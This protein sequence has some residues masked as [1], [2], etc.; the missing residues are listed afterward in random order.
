MEKIFI[1]YSHKDEGWKERLVTHLKVLELEGFF[2]IWE[3]RQIKTGDDWLPEIETALNEVGIVIM[4]ISADFLVSGFIRGTEVPKIMERRKNEGIWVIPV[5]VK[6][7]PWKSVNWLSVIQS[8]PRDG[9]DLMS[10]AESEAELHLAELAELIVKRVKLKGEPRQ[11][12][13]DTGKPGFFPPGKLSLSKLPTPAGEFIGREMELKWL[14]DAW[15]DPGTHIVI[16]EAWGGVGKTAL[17]NKWL[18]HMGI[19]NYRGAEKVYG[20]SF[21]S[22]GAAEGKQASADEFIQ[23]TL[24][25]FGDPNP[26]EGAAYEKG[27]RLASLVRQQKTLLILD[28]LEPLQHPSKDMM[29][30]LKDQGLQALLKEL[31]Y[32]QPGLCIVTTRLDVKELAH[33]H[34]STVKHIPLENLSPEVGEALLRKLEVKGTSKEMQSASM[35][36]SGHALALTLLGNYLAAVHDGEIRKKDLIPYLTE[37]EEQGGHARRVM[38][39]Y[40]KWFDNG[41]EKDILYIIR[42]FDRP[43]PGSAIA[44]LREA[45]VIEG[46]TS[47][48]QNLSHSQWQFAVKRLRRLGLLGCQNPGKPDDLDCHPLMRQHFGEKL[49]SRKPEAWKAAHSRL[50]QYYKDL[51]EKEFPDTLQEM[52]PLLSTVAHGCQAGRHQEAMVDVFWNRI[53]RKELFYLHIKIGAP[54]ANLA[55][56]SHF[57][58]KPWEQPAEGLSDEDKSFVLNWTGNTLKA[59]GRLREAIQPIKTGLNFQI[60]QKDWRNVSRAKANLS[61]IALILGDIPLAIDYARQSIEYADRIKTRKDKMLTWI[62]KIFNRTILAYILFQ[63]GEESEA[64]QWFRDA[65]ALQ[66][67]MQ[68]TFPYLYSIQGFRFCDLLLQQGRYKETIKRTIQTLKWGVIQGG[69]LGNA[70]CRL[71]LGRAWGMQVRE[72]STNDFTQAIEYLHH[73]VNGLREAGSQDYLFYGLLARAECYRLHEKYMEAWQ[74]LNEALEIAERGEMKL[75]LTDY[76][77]EAARLCQAE[78]KKNEAKEHVQTAAQLIKQTG[79]HRRDREVEELRK[80]LIKSKNEK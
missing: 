34:D 21:Y 29:G 59:E 3:D 40:E 15:Q 12:S 38:E 31:G 52:E 8:F 47:N 1:S 25:W 45:P 61:N 56:L 51:P 73:A 69:K 70:L 4:M 16:L 50:Y 7:C 77:L 54:G 44:A 6:P 55:A 43:A 27:K 39:S 58:C 46:V 78:G 65:E 18:T 48:L 49:E 14:D 9:K 66:K 35:E 63:A 20:W 26:E 72:D 11:E 2:H 10:M 36:F 76:H 22:Q 17:V 62:D 37:D 33:M 32:A 57:F 71:T 67:K 53:Y 60:A 41:P 42:L 24:E 74:D 80:D 28:G 79:Y 5:I 13:G 23:Q 19:D 75:Y 64:S 30:Q 68:P